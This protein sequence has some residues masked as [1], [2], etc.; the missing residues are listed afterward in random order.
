MT[1]VLK[2]L[3]LK[4]LGVSQMVVVGDSE[5]GLIDS[6]ATAALRQGS[7]EEL[8]RA[9]KVRVQLA[10]GDTELWLWAGTL[11][12]DQAIQPIIPVPSVGLI[13]GLLSSILSRVFSPSD[14]R[15]RAQ[16]SLRYLRSK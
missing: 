10:V 4:K 8:A 6:G 16:K 7:K 15:A 3:G 5:F 14:C 2:S 13:E 9:T 12:S 1:E 11:L